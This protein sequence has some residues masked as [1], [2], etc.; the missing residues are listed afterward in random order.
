M[1]S[2]TL[3][4]F[5]DYV[6][7]SGT[8]K[9]TLVRN[10]KTQYQREDDPRADFYKPLREG[11]IEMHKAGRDLSYLDSVLSRMTDAKK[12]TSYPKCIEGYAACLGDSTLTTPLARPRSGHPPDRGQSQTELLLTIDGEQ[13]MVKLY[14]KA[15]PIPRGAVAP[16]LRMV[17]VSIPKS[18]KAKPAIL[19]LQHAKL[20]TRSQLDPS[21][22]ALLQ[23]EA[24]SLALL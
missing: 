3:T 5:M 13:Y 4:T 23:A 1:A 21:L 14:F 9:I 22:D 20:H 7:V 2:V 6:V 17:Q 12:L 18:T 10:A 8:R 16:M 19:D 11:N 15:D 24:A